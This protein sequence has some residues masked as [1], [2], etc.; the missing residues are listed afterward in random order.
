MKHLNSFMLLVALA[1]IP[2]ALLGTPPEDKIQK[3]RFI[4]D[5]AQNYMTSKIYTL[6]HQKANDVVPF[7]LGAVKR[8][9]KNSTAD[10]INY[11]AG[12]QQLV[13]VTCPV[14]LIPYI[15]ELI[16][17][18][19]R[20]GTVIAGTGITRNVYIPQWRPGEKLVNLMVKTGISANASAGANQDAVVAYDAPT[21]QIY[22][23]DSANKDK[24]LKKYLSFLD[25]PV[26]QCTVS[27]N[28]YEI[29]ESDLQDVGIDYLAWKNGL[30]LNLFEAGANFITGEAVS[31]AFG[32]Y[33]FF[34]FAPAFDMSFIRILQQKGIGKVSVSTNV[35]LT[36]GHDAEINF[37]PNF[38]NLVKNEDFETSVAQSANNRLSLKIKSPVIAMQD[39]AETALVNFQYDLVIRSVIERD[40][41]G[42]ELYDENTSSGK[43][44]YTSGKE[45][46]LTSYEG[47]VDVEQTIGVPFL[48]EVPVLKYIF[49]TTTTNK[50]KVYYLV[51]VKP[52]LNMADKELSTFSGKV[53]QINEL[54]K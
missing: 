8:Y 49:G 38:Q 36:N 7:V 17:K 21:N 29:R 20:P 41:H 4:E 32:P 3:V 50:E 31:N 18:L 22:W 54:T 45:H 13:A 14:Q 42:N 25:R 26:S 35:T 28:V 48:C 9:A 19:D 33:G 53:T 40:N 47:T 43:V 1:T 30:G 10:R 5:D 37:V 44:S 52:A 27:V 6:K 16:A 11:S 24:D 39:N 46:L 23:K 12:K 34:M 51:S 15:D 2:S